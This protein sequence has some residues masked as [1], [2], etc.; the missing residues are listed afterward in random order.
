MEGGEKEVKQ[1]GQRGTERRCYE[2][3]RSCAHLEWVLRRLVEALGDLRVA[4]RPDLA[5][6]HHL[7]PHQG[8]TKFSFVPFL[9]GGVGVPIN[10]LKVPA[11]HTDEVLV[12]Q[13]FDAEGD[14]LGF[15][16]LVPRRKGLSERSIR[17]L[18]ATGRRGCA[19][20][21]PL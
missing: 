16:K 15:G 21:L 3:D 5:R 20:F 7:L 12:G 17:Q 8:L 19:H 18:G 4:L 11:A 2:R 10:W 13:A 9:K 1:N 6:F 14:P